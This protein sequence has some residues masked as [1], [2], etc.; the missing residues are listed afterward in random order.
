[1]I[2][3][4]QVPKAPAN[5]SPEEVVGELRIICVSLIFNLCRL[6]VCSC[7]NHSFNPIKVIFT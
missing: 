4:L 7:L 5:H 6:L 3:R 2:V 1:M